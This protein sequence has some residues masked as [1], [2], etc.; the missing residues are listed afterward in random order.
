MLAKSLH[1]HSVGTRTIPV[2]NNEQTM[3]ASFASSNNFAH[4]MT[5]WLSMPTQA[6]KMI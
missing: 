2:M 4:G 6:G 1:P 3:Q 5:D